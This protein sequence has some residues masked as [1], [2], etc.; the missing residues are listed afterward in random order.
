MYWENLCARHSIKFSSCYCEYFNDWHI[1]EWIHLDWSSSSSSSF[2]LVHIYLY[3]FLFWKERAKWKILH[4]IW[5]ATP[6]RHFIS[7]NH[8]SLLFD[9]FRFNLGLF[10]SSHFFVFFFGRRANGYR[11]TLFSIINI[12]FVDSFVLHKWAIH[13]YINSQHEWT[14]RMQIMHF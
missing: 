2:Y 9:L 3:F 7:I 1:N 10:F 13:I 5:F 6:I 11:V 8:S 14:V 4:L 12:S